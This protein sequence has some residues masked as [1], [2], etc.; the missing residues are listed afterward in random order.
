[1]IYA[2]FFSVFRFKLAKSLHSLITDRKSD[3]LFFIWIAYK[4]NSIII[5]IHTSKIFVS[6][7][8]YFFCSGYLH[9]NF[10]NRYLY[11]VIII[12]LYK[13]D[14]QYLLDTLGQYIVYFKIN[15]E[16]IGNCKNANADV[17]FWVIRFFFFLSVTRS[18]A[19]WCTHKSITQKNQ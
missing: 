7:H 15:N 3:K 10:L 1:M 14:I 17:A 13:N 2:I 19:F 6:F 16:S 9:H 11:L 12:L 4:S 5:N 18:M 8:S